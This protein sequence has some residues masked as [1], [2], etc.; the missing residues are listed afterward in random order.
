M[1]LDDVYKEW[2]PV[3][4]R[5]VKN[6]TLTTYQQ[7]Y[8]KKIS[9]A[10]GNM[11]VELLNKKII[12]PFLHDLMDGGLAVKT[13]NDILI[14]LK[15]LLQFA[16]EELEIKTV[17]PTW[18]MVWPSRNKSAAQ[19]IERYSPAEYK[20]IVEYALD[21]PS[22]RNLGI[23]IAICSGMRIGELCALQ[24]KDIDLV[25]KTMHVCKTLE[26]IYAPGDDGTFDNANTYIEIGTPKTFNSDRYIPILKNILPIIKK[27]AAV[28]KP[29]YYVCTCTENHTEPRTFRVYYKSFIL[30]MVKLDH[31]IKFHGLRHTFATT[32]IE[33]KIDVKTVST[34]LGHS[35]VGTTL[36]LYVHPS[37][38]AKTDAV[39]AGLKNMFKS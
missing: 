13:C 24:W 16:K 5:Q 9:P 1:K 28:C 38:Q 7:I 3:K 30:E 26:R 21:N 39:N 19:K 32:L 17:A 15:M 37:S 11:E 23:L 34:I 18:K 33:N 31:C 36:N 6:S 2:I 27:F 8:M 12:V 14:V 22:P 10:F 25:N 4:E 35:D 20:K 29:D